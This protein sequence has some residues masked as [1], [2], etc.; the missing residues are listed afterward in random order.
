MAADLYPARALMLEA[1]IARRGAL[2]AG[3][4]LCRSGQIG[5]QESVYGRMACSGR[6]HTK[7]RCRVIEYRVRRLSVL[8]VRTVFDRSSNLA[9]NQATCIQVAA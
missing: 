7:S 8:E 4:I 2:I 3:D 5:E 1:E 9:S 6:G